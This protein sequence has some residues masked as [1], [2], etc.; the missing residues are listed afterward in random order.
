MLIKCEIL[1]MEDLTLDWGT[2]PLGDRAY[3]DKIVNDM[4][5]FINEH[6]QPLMVAHEEMNGR[7]G[8]LKKVY[9]DEEDRKVKVLIDVENEQIQQDI[10]SKK[11]K[12]VS[13]G[14]QIPYEGIR[15]DHYYEGAL[16]EVSLTGIPRYQPGDDG[17]QPIEIVTDEGMSEPN[18]SEQYSVKRSQMTNQSETFVSLTEFNPTV[19]ANEVKMDMKQIEEIIRKAVAE[20]VAADK[21]PKEEAPDKPEDKEEAAETP[22]KEEATEEPK[23]EEAADANTCGEDCPKEQYKARIRELET[24]LAAK[25][26]EEKMTAKLSEDLKGK[27]ADAATVAALRTLGDNADAYKAMLSLIPNTV[28]EA[29]TEPTKSV[30]SDPI[31]RAERKTTSNGNAASITGRT[32]AARAKEYAIKNNIS[33]TEAMGLVTK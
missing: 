26:D 33:F 8:T 28:S 19:L 17:Q 1:P 32:R 23:K 2:L 30:L 25:E 9:L 20:A 5:R 24:A 22:E 11:F 21:A 4:D 27:D 15:D 16:L 10:Q 31:K 14:F 12:Y 7:Y 3:L 6:D 13:A 29:T 18:M